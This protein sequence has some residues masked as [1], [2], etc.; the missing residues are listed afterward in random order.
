MEW[1]DVTIVIEPGVAQP[2][3]ATR[4]VVFRVIETACKTLVTGCKQNRR[5]RLAIDF[6]TDW[7]CV[8]HASGVL[9]VCVMIT[10]TLLRTETER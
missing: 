8:S 10:S 7:A 6:S 3:A 4:R 9:G 1:N 2:G 5:A